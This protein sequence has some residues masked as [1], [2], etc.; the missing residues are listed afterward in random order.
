M[1]LAKNKVTKTCLYDATAFT[2]NLIK[3]SFCNALLINDT[4]YYLEK[5]MQFEKGHDLVTYIRSSRLVPVFRQEFKPEFKSE[6]WCRLL[7]FYPN[8]DRSN[9]KTPSI[10][11]FVGQKSGQHHNSSRIPTIIP[12]CKAAGFAF[13]WNISI[14]EQKDCYQK[15]CYVNDI[16]LNENWQIVSKKAWKMWKMQSSKD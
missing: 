1:H 13:W 2:L 10:F 8:C 12:I 16:K 7:F 4:F 15:Y 14:F 3:H 6:F 11:N 9:W 5:I